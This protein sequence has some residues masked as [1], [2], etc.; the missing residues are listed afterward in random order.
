VLQH[1]IMFNHVYTARNEGRSDINI[2]RIALVCDNWR[3]LLLFPQIVI[4][5]MHSL[6]HE[7]NLS[8]SFLG[9]GAEFLLGYLCYTLWWWL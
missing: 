5:K 7:E 2:C 9:C 6:T 1:R 8:V 3:L 4:T